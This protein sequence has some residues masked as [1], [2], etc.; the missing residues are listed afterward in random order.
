MANFFPI[1]LLNRTPSG[2]SDRQRLCADLP[3]GE[4]LAF[5]VFNILE[6]EAINLKRP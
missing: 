3:F 2:A 1:K 6:A 4:L 5:N